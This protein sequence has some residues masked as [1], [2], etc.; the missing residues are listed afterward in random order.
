MKISYYNIGCKVNYAEISELMEKFE[1]LGNEIVP[2]GEDCDAV[3]INTCTVT[4]QADADAR[5]IIR[6]AHRKHPDAFIGIIGCYA[7][8]QPEELKSLE[9]VDAIVGTKQKYFLPEIISLGKRTGEPMI[10]VDDLNELPYHGASSVDNES[11]SRMVLK[12]QDGCDYPCTYCTIPKARGYSR[13]LPFEAL[14]EKLLQLNDSDFYEIILSGINLGEYKAQSGENFTDVCRLIASLS[15]KQR[16][17]IS[18]IEPNLLT[19]EILSIVKSSDSFCPH[20]HIPLQSGSQ[21]ILRKMKRRYKAEDFSNLIIKIKK[22]IPDCCIGVDVI[23]G[24]PGESDSHFKETY[25]LLSALPVSYLHAFSYSDRDFAEASHFPD[26]VNGNVK[27]HRTNLLRELSDRK[28]AEFYRSQIGCVGT[29]IPE[30]R[31]D[32][33]HIEGWTENYVRV[34]IHDIENLSS[35]PKHPVKVRLLSES[36][37][38]IKAEII[39]NP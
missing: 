13:S 4:N 29:I 38:H 39:T 24:F 21:E 19:D 3:I 12:I 31:T 20:F 33:N 34:E 36:G 16:F 37:Q 18:S 30:I 2:F 26:K 10:L 32:R 1:E 23:S 8:L 35:F 25:D 14:R 7:Q 27:K 28:K 5:K 15:L 17:R 11:H 9:G 6:R 22:E